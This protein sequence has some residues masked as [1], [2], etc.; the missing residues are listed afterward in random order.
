MRMSGAIVLVVNLPSNW[1]NSNA[2]PA[3]LGAIRR[4]RTMPGS[5]ILRSPH[6]LGF[7]KPE[8]LRQT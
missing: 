7:P 3:Q 8:S 2:M 4:T 6:F 5:N 1:R